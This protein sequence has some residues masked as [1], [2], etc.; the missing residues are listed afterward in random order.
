MITIF[1]ETSKKTSSE[2]CFVKALCKKLN[3]KV[4]KPECA[5]GLE[6]IKNTVI[7]SR[8]TDIVKNKEE[9]LILYVGGLENIKNTVIKS[10]ITDIVKNKEKALI[11]F[12]ADKDINKRRKYLEQYSQG[13]PVFLFPNNQDKGCFENLLEKMIQPDKKEILS[14]FEKFQNCIEKLDKKYKSPDIK[15]KMYSYLS[16]QNGIKNGTWDFSDKKYWDWENEHLNPL[17]DCLK[18]IA[19]K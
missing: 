13:I 11:L 1:L 18:E 2:A 17:K 9:A 12:D 16:V 7:K 4:E 8:I 3:I 10:K 14:C 15:A 19:N 6:N 5:G